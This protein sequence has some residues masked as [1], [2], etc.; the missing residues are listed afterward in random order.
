MNSTSPAPY[1][2]AH[3]DQMKAAQFDQFTSSAHDFARYLAAIRYE[4]IAA[5]FTPPEATVVIAS[6]VQTQK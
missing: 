3:D 5:G 1:Q 6:W 4:L 2:V